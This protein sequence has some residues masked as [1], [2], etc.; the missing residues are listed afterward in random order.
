[1][2]LQENKESKD[3]ILKV[4]QLHWFKALLEEYLE[5]I[6]IWIGMEVM[7]GKL[8]EKIVFCFHF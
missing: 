3:A 4:K 6:P 5:G 7:H 1:M 2:D 8:E